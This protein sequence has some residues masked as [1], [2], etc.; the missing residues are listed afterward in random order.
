MRGCDAI[1][2]W[3]AS[4]AHVSGRS[5]WRGSCVRPS[6]LIRGAAFDTANEPE[7]DYG[8]PAGRGAGARLQPLDHAP[9]RRSLATNSDYSREEI[10]PQ[11][12]GNR[13]GGGVTGDAPTG[14]PDP[15]GE[16]PVKPAEPLALT[17][18]KRGSARTWSAR[19]ASI[20]RGRVRASRR[21]VRPRRALRPDDAR[22]GAPR[23]T[24]RRNL[25]LTGWGRGRRAARPLP[26]A[27]AVYVQASRHEGF[28]GLGR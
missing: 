14:C 28:G 20:R 15:F 1:V 27:P 24:R 6:V 7:I 4:L 9:R 10:A 18:G 22:R 13:A 11:T 17:V 26:P 8:L 23:G 25:R 5:P 12:S 21:R 3:W 19:P 16:L 2:G